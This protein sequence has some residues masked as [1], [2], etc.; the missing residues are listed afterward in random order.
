MKNTIFALALLTATSTAHAECM[1][2]YYLLSGTVIHKDNSPGVGV[3]VGVAWQELGL[4][5]GPALGK[6][7]SQ[8]NYSI[9]V[10]FKPYS[11]APN[12]K[13]YECKSV[14]S[15]LKIS[16][17]SDTHHS[18]SAPVSVPADAKELQSTPPRIIEIKAAPLEL[19]FE[20]EQPPFIGIDG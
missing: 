8:G 9:L 18:R 2:V 19:D 3:H 10:E 13:W 6:T 1:S 12:G 4:V 14:L 16:A 11:H 17:Y 15:A 20:I 5:G 7:D